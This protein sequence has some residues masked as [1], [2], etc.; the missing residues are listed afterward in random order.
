MIIKRKKKSSAL[1][2]LEKIT[3]LSLTLGNTLWSIRT[4]DE[5]SQG[6]F[7]EKLGISKSYLSDLE[8]G[9]RFPSLR[10]AAEYAR[11]LGYSEAQFVRLCLQDMIDKEGL[12]L[13]IEL[14]ANSRSAYA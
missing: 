2:Q 1:K 9:R 5:E 6:T 7:S 12:D 10:K 3:G 11:I 14:H 13:T 4:C 8:C